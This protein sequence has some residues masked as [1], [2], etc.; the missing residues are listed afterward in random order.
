VPYS[1]NPFV[2]IISDWKTLSVML[3]DKNQP[4]FQDKWPSMRPTILKLLRQVEKA[5]VS[6]FVITGSRRQGP[7]SPFYRL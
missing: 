2:F 6:N 7:F 3:K 5:K 4:V 1:T